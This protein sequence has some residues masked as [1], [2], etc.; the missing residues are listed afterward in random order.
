M[1]TCS[2]AFEKC[3]SCAEAAQSDVG[4]SGNWWRF[5]QVLNDNSGYVGA[6]IVGVMISCIAIYFAW[7][8]YRRKK[9]TRG[10]DRE[11]S[12]KSSLSEERGDVAHD[13]VEV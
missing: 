12:D 8:K 13:Q 6:G 9:K 1:S 3:Q 10:T 2:I 4:L 7:N 5:W 11:R